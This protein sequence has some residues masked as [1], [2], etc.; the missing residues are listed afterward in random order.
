MVLLNP[1]QLINPDL[2]TYSG[3]DREACPLRLEDTN[4][5]AIVRNLDVNF[6]IFINV[7]G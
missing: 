7:I 1:H 6:I 2:G 5:I 3:I 4:S